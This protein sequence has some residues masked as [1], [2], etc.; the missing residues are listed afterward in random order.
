MLITHDQNTKILA[1]Y[2]HV[3]TNV[4]IK[5]VGYL[6]V[7]QRSMAGGLAMAAGL[8]YRGTSVDHHAHHT[9][10]HIDC[11]RLLRAWHAIARGFA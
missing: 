6:P 5:S 3:V 9:V 8:A 1:G 7:M 2:T 10:K 11:S 4:P